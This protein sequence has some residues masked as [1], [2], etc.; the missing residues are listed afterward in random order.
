MNRFAILLLCTS[1]FLPVFASQ[2]PTTFSQAYAA[3]QQAYQSGTLQEVTDA[4]MLALTLGTEKFGADSENTAALAYNLAN[5]YRDNRQY[6]EAIDAYEGV[7]TMRE[8]LYGVNDIATLEVKLDWYYAYTDFAAAQKSLSLVDK[9][10][11]RLNKIIYSLDDVVDHN[12][13]SAPMAYYLVGRAMGQ[14]G[15]MPSSPRKAK[16][17]LK[18]GIKIATEVW[19]DNDIRV[20]ELQYVLALIYKGDFKLSEAAERLEALA[21]KISEEAYSSHP[22]ALQA[23][24]ALV[25]IYSQSKKYDKATKH[26]QLIGKMTPWNDNLEPEPLY[27][28]RAYYPKG[29][30]QS[31]I[32]GE[33]VLKFDIDKDGYAQRP[34]VIEVTGDEAFAD[35]AIVALSYWRFAPKFIDGKAV[36]ATD[37]FYRL[38]FNI[39]N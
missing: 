32:E 7:V 1:L 35:S 12:P 31:G 34:E 17:V 33:V 30:A 5:A 38:T 36:V 3:Y 2:Q 23:H 26:C 19:G 24:A 27:K 16:S 18:D 10:T 13:G 21:S 37:N 22:W 14:T 15:Y 8:A 28:R 29:L 4:A 20:L 9:N 11:A 6:K 39:Y 25:N